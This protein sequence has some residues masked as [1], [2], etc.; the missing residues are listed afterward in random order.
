MGGRKREALAALAQC[1]KL[2]CEP[3]DIDFSP[4][5]WYKYTCVYKAL[6]QESNSFAHER[7]LTI[8]NIRLCPI[9]LRTRK[10][11]KA[12]N[13]VLLTCAGWYIRLAWGVPTT[14]S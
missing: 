7:T 4:H 6:S 14:L 11:F 10:I 1:Q 13:Q 12:Q 9:G 8:E 2:H 3:I 5:L